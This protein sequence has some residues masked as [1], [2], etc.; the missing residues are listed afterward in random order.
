MGDIIKFPSKRIVRKAKTP[1][2]KESEI[3]RKKAKENYFIEQL[4]EEIVLHMIHVLQDNAVK[5]KDEKFLRDLAVII[6]AIKSL[7]YRDFGR[8]HKMQAISDAL[9]TIKKLPDGKQVT[10]LDYSKIFVTKKPK[11][12]I[13]PMRDG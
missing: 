6:E 8:K 13:D 5:M 9:A 12:D 11:N 10:D 2:Q 4:S 7:I 1:E 3:K